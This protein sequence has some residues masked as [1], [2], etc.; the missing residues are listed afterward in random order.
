MCLEYKC[1]EESVKAAERELDLKN[2]PA[3]LK[4]DIFEAIILQ[5]HIDTMNLLAKTVDPSFDPIAF[6]WDSRLSFVNG[7]GKK[8]AIKQIAQTI[9]NKLKINYE[10][11]D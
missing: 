2:Y 7:I 6:D 8:E 1:F 9:S 5:D 4:P 10:P 3:T 11:N